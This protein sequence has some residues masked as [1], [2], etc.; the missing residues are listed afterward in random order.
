MKKDSDSD[1]EVI[2]SSQSQDEPMD[3]AVQDLDIKIINQVTSLDFSFLPTILE[4]IL[5][6]EDFRQY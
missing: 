6:P 4:G 3:K 5:D 1:P 2:D